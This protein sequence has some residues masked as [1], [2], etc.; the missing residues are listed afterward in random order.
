MTVKE[1]IQ[2]L[3]QLDP[4][5]HVF[6]R[7]YEGGYCDI[8]GFESKEVALDVNTAWYY[9][10]HEEAKLV[11]NSSLHVVVKGVIL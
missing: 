10:P 7:G 11:P 3:Q 1:L 8:N 2:Q 5:L 4:N 9:G 6:T